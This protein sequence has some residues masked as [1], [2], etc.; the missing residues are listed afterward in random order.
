MIQRV[1]TTDIDSNGPSSSQEA[2]SLSEELDLR[3]KCVAIPSPLKQLT[4]MKLK[5][6]LEHELEQFNKFQKKGISS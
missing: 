1:T 6:G 3:L 2:L 5:E 4:S